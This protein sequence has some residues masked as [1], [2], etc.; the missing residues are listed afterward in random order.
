[1]TGLGGN[2]QRLCSC[3]NFPLRVQPWLC[4]SV[5]VWCDGA[6]TELQDAGE[7]WILLEQTA[8]LI[9]RIPIKKQW[10]CFLHNNAFNQH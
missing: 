1:M 9:L 3:F 4:T 5:C 7:G 6:L 10:F 8:D 2:Q